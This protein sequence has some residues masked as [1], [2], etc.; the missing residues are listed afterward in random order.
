M[1][2]DGYGMS[3]LTLQLPDDVMTRLQSEAERQQVPV[4]DL[5]RAAIETYLND[6]EPTREAILEDLRQAMR[7]ALAGRVR[8]ARAVL[9]ELRQDMGRHADHR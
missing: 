1:R 7:D 2:L 6:D 3:E 5:V 8:P 4:D 9:S